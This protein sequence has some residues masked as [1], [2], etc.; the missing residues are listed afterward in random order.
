[1]TDLGINICDSSPF[2]TRCV[3]KAMGMFKKFG[4]S[5][6]EKWLFIRD[7]ELF[8]ASIQKIL[9]WDFEKIVLSHGQVIES[10]GRNLFKNAFG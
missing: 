5:K 6:F 4:W 3:F 1:M 10:N 7:S 9:C 8:A 2:V